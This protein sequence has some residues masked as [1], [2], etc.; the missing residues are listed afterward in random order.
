LVTQKCSACGQTHCARCL[1]VLS[2][3]S[4]SAYTA[5]MV[6]GRSR[7]V[8][9][10]CA[11]LISGDYSRDDLATRYSVRELRTFLVACK[12]TIAGCKEKADLIELAMKA[13][14]APNRLHSDDHEHASHVARLKVTEVYCIHLTPILYH[15]QYS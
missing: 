8:C 7:R 4:A 9:V 5:V 3:D 14:H 12:V 2:P 1:T 11:V 13:S 6:R 10:K 15:L